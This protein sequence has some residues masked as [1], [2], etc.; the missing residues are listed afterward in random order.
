MNAWKMLRTYV[1]FL[2]GCAIAVALPAAAGTARIP[3]NDQYANAQVLQSDPM[4]TPGRLN[5]ATTSKGEPLVLGRYSGRRTVWYKYTAPEDGNALLFFRQMDVDAY[6]FRIFGIGIYVGEKMTSSTLYESKRS[7]STSAISFK[8][9]AGQTYHIQVD[10]ENS[11]NSDFDPSLWFEIGVRQLPADVEIGMFL[12]RPLIL[13]NAD[14]RLD[15]IEVFLA[16][17]SGQEITYGLRGRGI[18]ASGTGKRVL[19]P[20]YTAVERVT[21]ADTSSPIGTTYVANLI[22]ESRTASGRRNPTASLPFTFIRQSHEVSGGL[23]VNFS[24]S[25]ITGRSNSTFTTTAHVKVTDGRTHKGCRF[26]AESS[27]LE[28]GESKINRMTAREIRGGRPFGPANPVISLVANGVRIF[29][30]DITPS[31]VDDDYVTFRCADG[32]FWPGDR[33]ISA[34]FKPYTFTERSFPQLLMVADTANAFGE[35]RAQ[36][37]TRVIVP[38]TVR[39]IGTAVQWGIRWLAPS[40]PPQVFVGI[41]VLDAAGRCSSAPSETVT[42]KMAKNAETH[43]GV[44]LELPPKMKE[45]D[46]QLRA[47][48]TPRPSVEAAH[49][50]FLSELALYVMAND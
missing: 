7:R 22:L 17:G 24:P 23:A 2:M 10:T 42:L 20:W 12:R 27:H 26:V 34:A 47:S 14:T 43:I 41:C 13:Q 4:V 45:I 19:A 38:V 1:F 49:L 50:Y 28:H 25:L 48:L 21:G 30:V 8:T 36:P 6:P 35:V 33:V 39:N 37:N 46:G 18:S 11:S 32:W 40:I 31:D 5:D 29:Q 3:A 15:Q 9:V 16:N 44:V